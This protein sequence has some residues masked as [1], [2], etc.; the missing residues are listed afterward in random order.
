MLLTERYVNQANAWPMSGRHILA[1]A[2]AEKVIVYQAYKP[3]IG[4]Y[5]VKHGY[6]GGEEFG[7]SR[8]SWIKTNFLWMMYRSAWGTKPGQEVTLAIRISRKFFDDLLTQAVESSFNL[9]AYSTQDEWQKAILT[10]SVRLQWD[11][12]HHPSGAPLKRRALQLG[13]KGKSLE[14]FGKHEILEIIDIS[15]FVAEQRENTTKQNL[16]NLITPLEQVYIPADETIRMRLG[17]DADRQTSEA[18]GE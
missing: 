2:D 17:L 3:S 18:T 11:P 7:Y 6:F 8:M 10:S 14:K 4:R 12:D 5:A 13:L 1:Q 15:S 16:P 9:G